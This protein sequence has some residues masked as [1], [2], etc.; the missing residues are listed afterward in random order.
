[1][2]ENVT[3]ANRK[4]PKFPWIFNDFHIFSCFELLHPYF[5][6]VQ[7]VYFLL[8]KNCAIFSL[9]LKLYLWLY[10]AYTW[11]SRHFTCPEIV[12]VDISKYFSEFFMV[13]V[14]GSAKFSVHFRSRSW[15]W[16]KIHRKFG[17]PPN[18]NHE[19]LQEIFR[20]IKI[21]DFGAHE[22]SWSSCICNIKSQKWF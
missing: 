22:M 17:R 7:A 20:N 1:M 18:K 13:F 21:H 12:N 11:A 16:P 9:Y 8:K 2:N 19:K 15:M 5:E 10:I 3:P 14:R 4:I 6:L